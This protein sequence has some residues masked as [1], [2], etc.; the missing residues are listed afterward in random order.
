MNDPTSPGPHEFTRPGQ[1]H[2]SRP[3]PDRCMVCGRAEAAHRQDQI[4]NAL[5]SLPVITPGSTPARMIMR[6]ISDALALPP[7]R[8]LHDEELRFRVL[9]QR[10]RII[11]SV[12]RRLADDVELDALDMA[13]AA[14]SIR[15]RASEIGVNYSTG[16]RM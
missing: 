11:A 8:A 5:E 15:D 10:C 16:E 1:V 12:T 9:D 14:A 2:E 13:V 6:A 7:G 3:A 4:S